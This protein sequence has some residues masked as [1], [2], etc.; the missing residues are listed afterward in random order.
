MADPSLRILVTNDDGIYSPGLA[1]L[2]AAASEFGRVRV[3]APSVEQSSMGHAITAS[4][5]LSYRHT[6]VQQFTAYAVDGTPADCV[7]LGAY[8]WDKVD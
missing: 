7:S 5:P 4:R 6:V 1:V 8:Q 3:V 2:A